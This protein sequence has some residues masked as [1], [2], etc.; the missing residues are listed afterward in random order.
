MLAWLEQFLVRY[1]ELALFLVIAAGYWIGSFKIGPFTLGPVTCALFAGLFVGHFAHVPVSEMTK[2]FLF[3]L[4]PVRSRLL[5]RPAVPAGAQARWNEADTAGRRCLYHRP[6]S[7]DP[8]CQGPAA[9]S[10][11]CGRAHDGCPQPERGHRYSD[12]CDQRVGPARSGHDARGGRR[13]RAAEGGREHRHRRPSASID[14]SCWDSRFSSAASLVF[15]QPF[16][17][18]ES[19]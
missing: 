11:L 4:F 12:G 16:R 13:D 6:C 17:S 19:R 14:S 8:R 3:L 7:F 18:A 10:G 1:P 9:R 15:S 5:G 2:S